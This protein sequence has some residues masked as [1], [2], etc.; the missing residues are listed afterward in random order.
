MFKFISSLKDGFTY[1]LKSLQ[2]VKSG[3]IVAHSSTQ[4]AF[5]LKG[6][7]KAF[8]HARYNDNVFGGW[9]HKGS[10]YFDSCKVFTDKEE[11]IKFGIENEQIA[12]FDL[13]NLQEIRL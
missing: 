11:A 5:G 3:I 10:F 13:D 4:N 2:P 6:F 9:Y 1:D 7:V 8:T 12:I